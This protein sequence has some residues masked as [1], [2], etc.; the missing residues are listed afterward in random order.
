M[1]M[2]KIAFSFSLAL[3][4]IGGLLACTPLTFSPEGTL[5]PS[6]PAKY[7]R[8]LP[9]PSPQSSPT[10]SPSEIRGPDSPLN[11]A[12]P[13]SG[14]SPTPTVEDASPSPTAQ[15]PGF[16]LRVIPTNPTL[17]GFGA[18]ITPTVVLQNA[19]GQNV[20]LA[21]YPLR[22]QST[23]T[24]ILQVSEAGLI[25]AQ[26]SSGSA[27]VIVSLVQYPEVTQ[28]FTVILGGNTSSGGGGGG[29]S[30]TTP[31]PTAT[32]LPTVIRGSIG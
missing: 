9:S 8:P 11:T 2:P 7:S 12:S 22:W 16:T 5:S 24:G 6:S 14:N 25:R 15:P 28:R 19:Q 23:N 31:T 27:D 29:G 1:S 18:S 4:T 26:A 32:P 10:P 21:D 20:S 3:L 13:S 17:S 30:S